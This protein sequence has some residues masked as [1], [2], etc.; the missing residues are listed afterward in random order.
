MFKTPRNTD[1]TGT[2]EAKAN[3]S[4]PLKPQQRK[5]AQQR[6][7]ESELWKIAHTRPPRNHKKMRQS[8]RES[9]RD[10]FRLRDDQRRTDGVGSI[11]TLR[12]GISPISP[13]DRYH[14]CR[15]VCN[16]STLWRL[17]NRPGHNQVSGWV[18]Y[19]HLK[20][21][22]TCEDSGTVPVRTLDGASL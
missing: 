21:S 8:R 18:R 19:S 7:P 11:H 17:A 16:Y 13:V 15:E 12:S 9:R 2:G 20:P 6:I 14:D 4:A 10:W 22:L 1:L 5:P 3:S